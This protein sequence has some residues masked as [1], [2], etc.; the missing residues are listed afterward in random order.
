[1]DAVEGRS[2]SAFGHRRLVGIG[3]IG[4]GSSLPHR[5]LHAGG[6]TRRRPFQ[7]G[8]LHRRPVLSPPHPRWRRITRT[9]SKFQMIFFPRLI[10]PTSSG[11][12]KINASTPAVQHF[13][14]RDAMSHYRDREFISFQHTSTSDLIKTGLIFFCNLFEKNRCVERG[15]VDQI[16]KF[17][18]RF[19]YVLLKCLGHAV[20]ASAPKGGRRRRP[21]FDFKQ[22]QSPL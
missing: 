16:G 4:V 17:F 18:N 15:E 6:V 1:M 2:G 19:D 11:P 14:L 22:Q 9:S 10:N 20:P 5:L 7:E 8:N 3:Q 12:L 13:Y 21:S